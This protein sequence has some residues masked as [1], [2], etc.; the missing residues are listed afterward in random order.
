VY[1]TKFIDFKKLVQCRV[2]LFSPVLGWD[3]AVFRG[4]KQEVRTGL[5]SFQCK[6]QVNFIIS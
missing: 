5:Q 1:E 6:E 3:K 4:S 2:K